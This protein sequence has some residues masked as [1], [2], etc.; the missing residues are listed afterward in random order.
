MQVRIAGACSAMSSAEI[1]RAVLSTAT[2][3]QAC[4]TGNGQHFE[5]ML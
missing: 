2:R 4:M 3:F 1:Q 5:H